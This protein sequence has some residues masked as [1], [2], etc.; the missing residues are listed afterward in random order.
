ML[1]FKK[2]KK[3]IK[4]E[5]FLEKLQIYIKWTTKFKTLTVSIK[6]MSHSRDS[7]HSHITWWVQPG[8]LILTKLYRAPWWLVSL[9][10]KSNRPS[11]RAH[12]VGAQIDVWHVARLARE[13]NPEYILYM[14]TRHIRDPWDLQKQSTFQCI[15]ITTQWSRFKNWTRD[16]RRIRR[17]P[18][19]FS[20]L[21]EAFLMSCVSLVTVWMGND[22][23]IRNRKGHILLKG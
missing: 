3:K 20:L 12:L 15:L 5:T 13:N 2:K 14:N 1:L 19:F 6:Y 17:L 7:P 22:S 21:R 10:N 4:I 8:N 23:L 11:I 18:F 9:S 16:L